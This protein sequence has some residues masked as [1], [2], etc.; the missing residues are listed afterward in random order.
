MTRGSILISGVGIA[1]PTLAYWLE[2]HGFAPTLVESAPGLRTGGYVIDFWGLGYEIAGR[3]GLLPELH[4]VGYRM[5]ELRIV[6]DRGRRVAGF[7]T[8]V[9]DELTD[10]HFVSIAR[11]DLSRL[12]FREIEGSAEVLFGDTIVDLREEA[13]GIIVGFARAGERRFD[14]VI[15]ADG[16]HSNVRRLAFGPPGDFEAHLGYMVAAFEAQGYRPRDELTYVIYGLPG[17]MIGRFALRDDRTLFLL[18]YAG[19]GDSP[20]DR[21]DLAAQKAIVREVYRDA[22]WESEAILTALDRS[23]DLYFDRVSQIR[24]RR[25]SRGRVALIGDAA[26]C[27]SLLAGQG[28]A[29]AMTSAYVLAGELARAGGRHDEAFRRYESLLRPFIAAKQKGAERFA[30]AF[31]PRTRWGM[32]FRNQVVKAFGI[33]LVSRLA[34][35][36]DLADR[37]ELPDYPTPVPR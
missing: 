4:R 9:F 6:D 8:G 15:G 29:L 32:F 37:L 22:R 13:D 1:G 23:D 26:F 10:G 20:P 34:L 21:H 7:G 3:M 5:R 17:R 16:L 11:S 25:W 30:G 18:V 35:G 33:P 19:H 14:L 12:I 27:V 2:R 31:A 28:S 36:R 24:M